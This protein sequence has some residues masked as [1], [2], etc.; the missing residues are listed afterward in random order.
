VNIA[1]QLCTLGSIEDS[2]KHKQRAKVLFYSV[3]T[4]AELASNSLIASL[5]QEQGQD[6]VIPERDFDLI[7]IGHDLLLLPDLTVQHGFS[8]GWLPR[9]VRMRGS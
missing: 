5:L 8:L 1:S 3:R 2:G 7:E 6:L 9:I 4:D